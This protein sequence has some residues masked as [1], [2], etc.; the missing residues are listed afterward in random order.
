LSTIELC[1]AS[2]LFHPVYAG[3][4]LRFKRYLPGLRRRGILPTVFTST[5]TASR[6]AAFGAPDRW[7]HAPAGRV[8]PPEIVEGAP[9]YRLRQSDV[10]PRRRDLEYGRALVDFC[11]RPERRPDVVQFLPV[12]LWY[13]PALIQ[14]KRMGAPVTA[15]YNLLDKPATSAWKRPLQQFTRRLPLRFVD[16][17]IVNSS[18]MRRTLRQAG[19]GGRIE[20]APNGVDTTRF[21]PATD[22]EAR[23][24]LRRELNLPVEAEIIITVGAV[25]PRKGAD[26]LLAAWA[27]MAA[28]RPDSHVVIVGPR[29]DAQNP[30]LAPFHQT[31]QDQIVASGAPERVHFTGRVNNVADYLRAADL[32]VFPSVREGLPNVVLEAM[33]TAVPV[34]MLPFAGRAQELGR[35]GE[36]YVLVER[37]A[38]ALARAIGDLLA[39]PAARR[40]LGAA[41]QR[42]VQEEMAL[43]DTL[44]KLNA[45]YRDVAR[46]R[47]RRAAQTNVIGEVNQT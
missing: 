35:P 29:T 14:L 42:W 36:E 27:Q 10:G 13:T 20:V 6:L 7:R 23:Q 44:D 3:G 34:I 24:A 25:E 31:L 11:R 15:V 5:P 12:Q 17:V 38:A 30:T 37:D 8:M 46:P 47:R 22:D 41:G 33:A 16:C 28:E 2:R 4:A 26:W 43:D 21:Y 40:R 39:Q 18:L 9:V 1:L 32:F 45:I 19:I